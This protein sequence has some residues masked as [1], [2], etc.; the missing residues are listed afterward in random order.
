M[1][2]PS[3]GITAAGLYLEKLAGYLLPAH[4]LERAGVRRVAAVLP[5]ALLA[6]I[7]AV[8]VVATGHE[9]HLDARVP[10]MAVAILLLARRTNFLIMVIA[11]SATTA[12]VR[13]LGWMA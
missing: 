10:G 4:L 3:I 11:A 1:I 9:V 7:V 6:S 12:L 2:W 5:V 8:Q 13:Q